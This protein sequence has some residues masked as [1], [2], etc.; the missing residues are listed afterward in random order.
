MTTM[1]LTNPNK[2]KYN[3]FSFFPHH[4]QL[5]SKAAF[6]GKTSSSNIKQIISLEKWGLDSTVAYQDKRVT[7]KPIYFT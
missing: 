4:L 5:P 2:I 7:M 6:N 1:N 3:N